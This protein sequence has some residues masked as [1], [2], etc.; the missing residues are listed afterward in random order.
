VVVLPDDVG[1][2]TRMIRSA[3]RSR[4]ARWPGCPP[5]CRSVEVEVDD[6]RSRIRRTTLSRTRSAGSRRGCRPG[7][8]RSP[9]RSDRLGQAALAMSRFDMT[10]IR[11]EIAGARWRGAYQFVEHAS[12]DTASYTRPRTARSGCPSL[13]LIASS[14]TMFRS[15]RT[16]AASAISSMAR[17]RSCSRYGARTARAP[18]RSRSA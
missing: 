6:V 14:K 18:C 12:T 5:P 2:V 8:R 1:P 13:S 3:S 9:A 4:S 11:D 17:G 10:L 15:L 7:C 16:G